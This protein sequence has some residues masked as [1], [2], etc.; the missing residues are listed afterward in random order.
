MTVKERLHA[1]VDAL[2]EEQA[3]RAERTLELLSE[4]TKPLAEPGR[5][6]RPL[7]AFVGLATGPG[8]VVERMGE[9][10]SEGFGR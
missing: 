8:D 5:G 2:S 6:D 7:P 3:E 10:L 4:E 1:L 9:Y